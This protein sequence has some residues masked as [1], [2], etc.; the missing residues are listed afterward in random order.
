MTQ[1]SLLWCNP[2]KPWRKNENLKQDFF[3]QIRPNQTFWLKYYKIIITKKGYMHLRC[4][5]KHLGAK[6]KD[7]NL[8]FNLTDYP[9]CLLV[10]GAEWQTEC[11]GRIRFL[12]EKSI[13]LEIEM[14]QHWKNA[15]ISQTSTQGLVSAAG[16]KWHKFLAIL[17]F[18]GSFEWW[19]WVCLALPMILYPSLMNSWRP[20]EKSSVILFCKGLSLT[21]SIW[22]EEYNRGRCFSSIISARIFLKYLGLL[23]THLES[24]SV[25][26]TSPRSTFLFC[27][28]P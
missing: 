15:G 14:Y 2:G 3:K 12:K 20:Y 18:T 24:Q 9:C 19:D 10:P 21:K 22:L 5:C 4:H 8:P 1:W 11:V 16:K 25:T 13:N 28:F 6:A 7:W 26:S 17:H 23:I 27:S